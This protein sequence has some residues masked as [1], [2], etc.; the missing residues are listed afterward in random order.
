[1][2]LTSIEPSRTLD[3]NDTNISEL[4]ENISKREYDGFIK[5][6]KGFDEGY[7]LF[8]EGKAIAASYTEH[9]KLLFG[10]SDNLPPKEYK[11]ED[12]IKKIGII[13]KKG[14]FIIE[15]FEL[16][17]SQIDFAI[18]FNES[19]MLNINPKIKE[20]TPKIKETTQKIKETTQKIKETTPKIK[21]TTPKIKE[22]TQK[23]PPT[24]KIEET[25]SE[26]EEIPEIKETTQK[27]PQDRKEIMDKYGIKDPNEDELNYL[28]K[29]LNN[30]HI[31]EKDLENIEFVITDRI[32][33]DIML[34]PNI[35]QSE[36]LVLVEKN[37][38]EELDG[39][40]NIILEYPPKGFFNWISGQYRKEQ[41]NLKSEIEKIINL[42]IKKIFREFTEIATNFKI[43][44]EIS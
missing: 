26:I 31:S 28:L 18:E 34:I 43:N 37:H 11:K 25:T 42:E 36:V 13:S 4:I 33:R 22:T 14:N 44:I 27:Q 9:K 20:T 39:N 21:E 3:S 40:I 12:A 17:R 15:V 23:Q 7:I 24:P 29:P 16:S 1:M 2:E 6:T 32:K 38:D 8:K 10:E 5:I 19:Y 30:V 35:K 41:D